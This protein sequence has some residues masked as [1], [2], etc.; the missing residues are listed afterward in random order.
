MRFMSKLPRRR[1]A[2]PEPRHA[3]LC[4]L[5][6]QPSL[7]HGGALGGRSPPSPGLCKRSW[8]WRSAAAPRPV[9]SAPLVPA[10]GV[11]LAGPSR[12]RLSFLSG[13]S[14][15]RRERGFPGACVAGDAG[16]VPGSGRSP[17]GRFG[18]RSSA[19]A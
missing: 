6:W 9:P 11:A 14:E 12:V 8:R 18:N 17:G 4:H 3:A 10:D 5:P 7:P 2:Q 13:A 19:L 16:S 1:S 15:M